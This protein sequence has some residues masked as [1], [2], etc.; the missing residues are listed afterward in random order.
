MDNLKST[1]RQLF[2]RP[3]DE[4]FSTL[5]ELY[6]HCSDRQHESTVHWKSPAEVIPTN[7]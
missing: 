3:E 1:F 7:I 6:S 4:R 2:S 5:D